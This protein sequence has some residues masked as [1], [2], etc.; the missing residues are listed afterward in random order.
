M[1]S[2]FASSPYVPLFCGKED[3]G[4]DRVTLSGHV[5]NQSLVSNDAGDLDAIF[6]GAATGPDFQ[7]DNRFVLQD[8]IQSAIISGSSP[9]NPRTVPK[10]VRRR[11]ISKALAGWISATS[12]RNATRLIT[13]VA[14]KSIARDKLIRGCGLSLA[15]I[16]SQEM[17]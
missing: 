1:H 7:A 12:T 17:H 2:D 4:T 10:S 3:E 5:D 9:R 16:D 15:D 11:F 13:I 14:S 8:P 6:E